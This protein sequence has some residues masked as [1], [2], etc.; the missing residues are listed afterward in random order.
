M[1]DIKQSVRCETELMA[2]VVDVCFE[3]DWKLC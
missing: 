2:G 1:V 3:L